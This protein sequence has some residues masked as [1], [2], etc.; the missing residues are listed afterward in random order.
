MPSSQQETTGAVGAAPVAENLVFSHT[1]QSDARG[2]YAHRS[3]G[4]KRIS[5]GANKTRFAFAGERHTVTGQT[6]RALLALVRA[7]TSGAT[8]QEESSW[9]WRFAAYVHDLRRLGLVIDM[10]R[11]AHPGGWHGRYRLRS[12]VTLLGSDPAME[13]VA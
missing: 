12:P 9:A 7:G 8:A 11:E 2:R 13:A 10:E 6:A 5:H 1:P 3:H 4:A